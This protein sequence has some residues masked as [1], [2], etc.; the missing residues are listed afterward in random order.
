M[1]RSDDSSSDLAMSSRH[2]ARNIALSDERMD[3][4]KPSAVT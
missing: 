1:T 2:S 3:C 4:S